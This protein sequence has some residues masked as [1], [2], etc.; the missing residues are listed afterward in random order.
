MTIE[1][2]QELVRVLLAHA[3]AGQP[4]CRPERVH[5]IND[6]QWDHDNARD[7]QDWIA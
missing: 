3:R 5:P 2:R 1:E 7:E 6:T 4:Q